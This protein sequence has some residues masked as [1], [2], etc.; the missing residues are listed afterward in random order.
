[1]RHHN[2]L[3]KHPVESLLLHYLLSPVNGSLCPL[4]PAQPGPDLLGQMSQPFVGFATVEGFVVDFSDGNR[5]GVLGVGDASEQP[6]Q[7]SKRF[8]H[9]QIVMGQANTIQM[10]IELR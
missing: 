3:Q 5:V 9:N 8:F 4:R 1:M 6:E 2:F 7:Q 10:E